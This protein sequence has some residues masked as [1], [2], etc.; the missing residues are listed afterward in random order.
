MRSMANLYTVAVLAVG[1][2]LGAPAIASEYVP[3]RTGDTFRYKNIRFGSEEDVRITQTSGGWRLYTRF[4]NMPNMWV[5]T[6]ATSENVYLWNPQAGTYELLANFAASVGATSRINIGCNAGSVRV[7]EKGLQVTTAAGT[8]SDCVRLS[9][10]GGG[11][12]DAGLLNAWF[13][14]GI[15]LVKWEEKNI[16]GPV[17]SELVAGNIGGVAYPAAPAAAL[18]VGATLSE[19]EAY[20]NLMPSVGGPRPPK[21]VEAYITVE[22]RSGSDISFT[23]NSGQSFEVRVVNSSGTTVSRWS[24]GRFFTQAIR[25]V[26]LKSGE[27]WQYGGPVELTTDAGAPLPQG[28]YT[29]VVELKA[30]PTFS[31]SLPLTVGHAY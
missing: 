5:W 6:S 22:N 7:A 13:A 9:F 24:R 23:F 25:Q 30:A 3:N 26:T 1:A 29:V 2:G 20:I 11:C 12:S 27:R 10:S 18:D 31:A 21:T 15:G 4:A 17:S 8:F 16:A 14:K 19:Y 28:S